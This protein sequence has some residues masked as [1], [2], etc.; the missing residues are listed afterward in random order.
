MAP[1]LLATSDR[2]KEEEELPLST[3]GCRCSIAAGF[4]DCHSSIVRSPKSEVRSPKSEVRSP[5][6]EVSWLSATAIFQS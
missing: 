3:Q 6:S 4:Y 2:L 1:T 5:K